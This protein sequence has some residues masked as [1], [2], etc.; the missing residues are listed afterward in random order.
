M[1]ATPLRFQSRGARP[2]TNTQLA[3][4]NQLNQF[5]TTTQATPNGIGGENVFPP[6]IP[7]LQ[8]F[9]MHFMLR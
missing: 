5:N 1:C 2:L 7:H 8:E 4:P 9:K 3:I 6:T